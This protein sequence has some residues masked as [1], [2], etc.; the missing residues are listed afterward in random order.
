MSEILKSKIKG[1][2]YGLAIGDSMGAITEFMRKSEIQKK[3]RKLKNLSGGGWLNLY[4]GEVTDPTEMTLC[5]CRALKKTQTGDSHFGFEHTFLDNC[6]LEFTTWLNS[7]PVDSDF[8]CNRVIHACQ[9]KPHKDWFLYA[10]NEK[11]FS[12]GQQFGNGSLLRSIPLILGDK[13]LHTIL[14]LSRLTH[15][16]PVC[17]KYVTEFCLVMYA[18]LDGTI[19]KDTFAS[20]LPEPT[21]H[22]K[23]TLECAHY[24]LLHSDSLEKAIICAVNEGGDTD[25]I[26]AATGSLAGAYYGYEAIPERWINALDPKV[27]KDLDYF[28]DYLYSLHNLNI[29][30]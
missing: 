23:N 12:Y 4:A 30:A 24:H 17:D 3:Y 27:K 7:H 6:C 21:R 9:S 10:K 16:N 14:S 11:N 29:S 8:C 13:S 25:V 22:I 19:L 2:L 20:S 26:G 28:S 5:V 15:N 18:C 1:T